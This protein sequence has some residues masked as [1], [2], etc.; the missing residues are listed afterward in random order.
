[1]MR[2]KEVDYMEVIF[3]RVVPK[4]TIVDQSLEYLMCAVI[5]VNDSPD[6]QRENPEKKKKYGR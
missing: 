1:M 2:A 6:P 4:M 3:S 5:H